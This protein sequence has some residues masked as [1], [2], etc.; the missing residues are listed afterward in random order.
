MTEIKTLLKRDGKYLACLLLIFILF[1]WAGYYLPDQSPAAARMLMKEVV[2]KFAKLLKMMRGAPLY[3]QI[4]LIFWNNLQA[5]FG[6]IVLGIIPVI[7]PFSML[8]GNALVIGLVLR[9]TQAKAGLSAAGFLLSLLP[10]GIF[11]IPAFLIAVMLGI[12]LGVIPIKGLWQGRKTGE[13]HFK[14]GYQKYF[15]EL[16]LY[17]LLILALLCIAAIL[18]ITV[19]ARIVGRT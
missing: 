17:G 13:F 12:R 6:A 11:E 14:S 5:A 18:E 7:I 8:T 1:V 9:T 3:L 19:S 2:A 10:H 15:Q 16:K 4:L